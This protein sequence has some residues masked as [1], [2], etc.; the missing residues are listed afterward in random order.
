M[1]V[2]IKWKSYCEITCFSLGVLVCL[3]VAITPSQ[4]CFLWYCPFL[5][6][7]QRKFELWKFFQVIL[8]WNDPL[9]L[10]FIL[11][12]PENTQSELD[13]K[14]MADYFIIAN[15]PKSKIKNQSA[16]KQSNNNNGSHESEALMQLK[17]VFMWRHINRQWQQQA[18]C[19]D[20]VVMEGQSCGPW[21]IGWDITGSFLSE[22][23]WCLVTWHWAALTCCSTSAE[24][25]WSLPV[26]TPSAPLTHVFLRTC[27]M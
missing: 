16:L 2:K 23:A 22:A 25:F 24:V 17:Q 18:A 12:H 21:F 11:T 8:N 14:T 19:L 5:C 9:F 7:L 13:P 10:L 4:T 6:S 26:H 27:L 1:N 20:S 15:Q 3:G